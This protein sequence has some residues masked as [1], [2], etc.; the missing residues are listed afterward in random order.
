MMFVD[1]KVYC[2]KSLLEKQYVHENYYY[3]SYKGLL[4]EIIENSLLW[5]IYTILELIVNLW[6]TGF[7]EAQ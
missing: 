7:S 1:D 3:V 5:I 4:G 2:Y 6:K